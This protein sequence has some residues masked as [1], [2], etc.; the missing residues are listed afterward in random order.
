MKF[1]VLINLIFSLRLRSLKISMPS[2]EIEVAVVEK[3]EEKVYEARF[4]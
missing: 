4:C 1:L 2:F 3:D